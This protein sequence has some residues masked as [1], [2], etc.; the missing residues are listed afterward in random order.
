RQPAVVR[1]TRS[2]WAHRRLPDRLAAGRM[3]AGVP[4]QG[5]SGE[6]RV[7]AHRRPRG[8][9][10]YRGAAPDARRRR[11]RGNRV[12]RGPDGAAR[13]DLPAQAAGALVN[14]YRELYWRITDGVEIEVPGEGRKRAQKVAATIA[15]THR[16]ITLLGTPRG[17]DIPDSVV[18]P[19]ELSL[20]L[21]DWALQ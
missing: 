17:K 6:R 14:T 2:R 18:R 8:D 5:R 9:H 1:Q 13:V 11:A 16:A 15:A 3:R 12:R 21:T 10:H 4:A 19:D 20:A 7:A